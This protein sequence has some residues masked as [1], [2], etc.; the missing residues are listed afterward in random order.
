[1]LLQWEI[2]KESTVVQHFLSNRTKALSDQT[3]I[4]LNLTP[5]QLEYKLLQI[6]LK[7]ETLRSGREV[8]IGDQNKEI[9]CSLKHNK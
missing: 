3:K 7:V 1:M 5:F 2:N 8:K 6:S 9:T 4:N